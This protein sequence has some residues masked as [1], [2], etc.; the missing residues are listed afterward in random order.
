MA[1]DISFPTIK[2]PSF[3]ELLNIIAEGF[4]SLGLEP[5]RIIVGV[6]PT[7]GT[8]LINSTAYVQQQGLKEYFCWIKFY[9]FELD[10]RE[11]N[12]KDLQFM[13]ATQTRGE[14]NHYFATIITYILAKKLGRV[15]YDDAHLVQK[16]DIYSVDELLPFVEAAKEKIYPKI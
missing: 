16:K 3:D 13:M 7:M 2:I 12:E 8:D 15:I 9:K 5:Y 10:L 4:I 6:P 14:E 11:E 1:N